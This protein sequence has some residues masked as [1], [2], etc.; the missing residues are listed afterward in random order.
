[1]KRWKK[2]SAFLLAAVLALGVLTACGQQMVRTEDFVHMVQRNLQGVSASSTDGRSGLNLKVKA[3]EDYRKEA[4]ALLNKYVEAYEA[5]RAMDPIPDDDEPNI[6]EIWD[7]LDWN[8]PGY[9]IWAYAS[10]GKS[11]LTAIQLDLDT[12]ARKM[13]KGLWKTAYRY[14][15]TTEKTITVAEKEVNGW[16]YLVAVSKVKVSE[17]QPW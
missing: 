12:K 17:P 16:Y 14:N 6:W 13:A 11:D 8:D 15:D 1:M 9:V 4:D 3:G 7:E 2:L 10:K 5:W